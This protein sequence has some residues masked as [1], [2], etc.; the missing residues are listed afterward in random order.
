MTPKRAVVLGAEFDVLKQDLEADVLVEVSC[1][2]G[3]SEA[4]FIKYL[5]YIQIGSS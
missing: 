5:G 1:E 3:E 4:I 2:V